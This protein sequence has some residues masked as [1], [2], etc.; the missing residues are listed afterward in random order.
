MRNSPI[1]L[2]RAKLK[3]VLKVQ[4]RASIEYG[5]EGIAWAER[6][7]LAVDR[8]RDPGRR[9]QSTDDAL[10]VIGLQPVDAHGL[11]R[12]PLPDRQQQPGDDVQG[13]VGELE[14]CGELSL[15][16]AGEVGSA[17]LLPM[18]VRQ[19]AARD[20]RSLHGPQQADALFDRAV[21]MHQARRR[22]FHGRA[23]GLGVDEK[24][25]VR[26][27]HAIERLVEP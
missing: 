4:D 12:E 2:A 16:C 7:G 24:P 13:A 8:L 14:H 11:V 6:R 22:H 17:R 9:T 19:I 21:V 18:G 25:R 3:A 27:I 5:S 20:C 15:P 26:T 1:T 10:A 23:S